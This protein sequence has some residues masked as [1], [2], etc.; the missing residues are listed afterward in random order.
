MLR[1]DEIAEDLVAYYQDFVPF[2]DLYDFLCLSLRPDSARRVLRVAEDQ[3][4]AR[5]CLFLK[6]RE[7]DLIS[8]SVSYPIIEETS[9]HYFS[10]QE[11]HDFHIIIEDRSENKHS[12]S[13]LCIL[14]NQ[15]IYGIEQRWRS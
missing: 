13:W 7:V 12:L 14:L 5:L 11:L 8:R 9:L 6:I 1:W 3:H 4:L 15:Q 2:A 10:L